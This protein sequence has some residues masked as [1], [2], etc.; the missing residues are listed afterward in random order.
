MLGIKVIFQYLFCPL[1]GNFLSL[2][3]IEDFLLVFVSP[4]FSVTSLNHAHLNSGGL[5]SA[6]SETQVVNSWPWVLHFWQVGIYWLHIFVACQHF[7][8]SFRQLLN[9][10]TILVSDL[11]PGM[12][13]AYGSLRLLKV[14]MYAL[15]LDFM[16]VAGSIFMTLQLSLK[17]TLKAGKSSSV[18]SNS[19]RKM[20]PCEKLSFGWIDVLQSIFDLGYS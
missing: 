14:T 4:A 18:M 12:H 17:S 15:D 1:D 20:R 16:K 19:R 2:G 5:L 6:T 11:S 13:K 8:Q 9:G 10:F 7:V 3:N